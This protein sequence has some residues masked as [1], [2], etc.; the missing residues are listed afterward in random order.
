[1]CEGDESSRMWGSERR[2][3]MHL[4]VDKAKDEVRVVSAK[5]PR[6]PAGHT[7]KFSSA[8][9]NFLVRLAY[10]REGTVEYV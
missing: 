9:G 8:L 1:M 7:L 2:C 3:F 4:I 10:R 5:S 6:L